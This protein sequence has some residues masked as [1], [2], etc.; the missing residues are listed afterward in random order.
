MSSVAHGGYIPLHPS[1]QCQQIQNLPELILFAGTF[2]RN[3]MTGGR[4]SLNMPTISA[5]L[6]P[7]SNPFSGLCEKTGNKIDRNPGLGKT[8]FMRA[9][10]SVRTG[11]YEVEEKIVLIGVRNCPLIPHHAYMQPS[12]LCC[13]LRYYRIRGDFD[14]RE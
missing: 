12:C 13:E 11:A 7:G 3:A 4:K 9:I 8:T 5:Y 2:E 14:N 10:S 6:H 1:R